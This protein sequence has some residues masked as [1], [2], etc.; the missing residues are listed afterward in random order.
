MTIDD[1]I[2]DT[3]RDGL[4]GSWEGN[5]MAFNTANDTR[6]A[7]ETEKPLG[8]FMYPYAEGAKGAL[9]YYAPQNFKY[10]MTAR[11]LKA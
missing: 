6:L 4:F 5:W 1:P 3:V 9:D 2:V 11:E 8:H 7:P 10:Q